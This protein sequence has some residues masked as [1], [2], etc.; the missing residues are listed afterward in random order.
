M[1]VFN[2]FGIKILILVDLEVLI[3]VE[4]LE[5]HGENIH[6]VFTIILVVLVDHAHL[7]NSHLQ[8]NRVVH[9]NYYTIIL[10]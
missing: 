9:L 8:G 4:E 7:F 1:S 10:I 3:D 6:K 2:E 5:N